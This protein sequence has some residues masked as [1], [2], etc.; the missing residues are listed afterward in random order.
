MHSSL[1]KIWKIPKG[2]SEAIIRKWTDNAMDLNTKETKRKIIVD[3]LLQI[4]IKMEQYERNWKA[5][6]YSDA[7]L[8]NLQINKCQHSFETKLI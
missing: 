6:M 3:K 2:Y 4:K 1:G 8:Y 5:G 7:Q